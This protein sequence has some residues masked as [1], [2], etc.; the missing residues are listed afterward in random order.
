MLRRAAAADLPALLAIRDRSGTD[1]LSDPARV[2]ETLLR[3][4]VDNGATIVWEDGEGIAGFAATDAA[5]IHLLVDTARRGGGIG[6]A[7]LDWA[8]GAVRNAGHPA[9]VVTLPQ[10]G[11]A[12]RHYRA[13]G[14]VTANDDTASE[15]ILKKSF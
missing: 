3:R 9:A 7:L 4:L 6:R 8:M 12:E 11:T 1:A 13:S 5:A 2:D 15:L 14:W 10:R